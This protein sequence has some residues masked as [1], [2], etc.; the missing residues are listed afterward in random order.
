MGLSQLQQP[1]TLT[2][3]RVKPLE[4]DGETGLPLGRTPLPQTNNL[5]VGLAVPAF[6]A[7]QLP[8]AI[9]SEPGS[10][11]FQYNAGFPNPGALQ[12][13]L[14]DGQWHPITNTFLGEIGVD[15]DNLNSNEYGDYY[16]NT[17]SNTVRFYTAVAD[18]GDP[19]WVDNGNLG[20]FTNDPSGLTEDNYGDHYY[21]SLT[22]VIRFWTV[23][24]WVTMGTTTDGSFVNYGGLV[25]SGESG[26]ITLTADT[27]VIIAPSG[28]SWYST[29]TLNFTVNTS[30]QTIT[31]DTG[32]STT[33]LVSLSASFV[34]DT[35]GNAISIIIYQNGAPISSTNVFSAVTCEASDFPYTARCS[36][37]ITVSNGDVFTA[38]VEASLDSNVSFATYALLIRDV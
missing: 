11:A 24:G 26:S 15:P 9:N 28:G 27:P 35:P 12:L 33:Q 10:L 30:D 3:L 14:N 13:F 36:G 37:I 7:G 4:I 22:N 17:N 16:Y 34:S 19:G 32:R 8:L 21:N 25:L 1:T 31:S 23:N 38:M 29:P 2:N 18:N 5:Y 6:P 20:I